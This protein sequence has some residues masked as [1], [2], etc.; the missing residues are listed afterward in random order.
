MAGEHTTYVDNTHCCANSTMR[1]NDP[2]DGDDLDRSNKKGVDAKNSV[3]TG[4]AGFDEIL[5][6]V[7]VD[8]LVA[9]RAIHRVD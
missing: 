5:M 8:A 6:A 2:C 3:V 7:D 1:Q 4:N 9:E